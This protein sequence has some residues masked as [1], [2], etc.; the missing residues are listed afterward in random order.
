MDAAVAHLLEVTGL[1]KAGL[2]DLLA[3]ASVVA[4]SE[5]VRDAGATTLEQVKAI[6][7]GLKGGE[8]VE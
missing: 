4:T 2:R 8:N 5:A 3:G 1:D 7:E 6:I